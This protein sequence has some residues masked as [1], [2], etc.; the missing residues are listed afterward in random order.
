MTGI[1]T[2]RAVES[3]LPRLYDIWYHDEIAGEEDTPPSGPPLSGF[4]HSLERG[5]MRVAVDGN[6]AIMGFGATQ[7]WAATSGPL[8]YL[9]DLFVASDT[10]SHGAGQALLSALPMGQGA[11]CVMASRDPRATALYIRWGMRPQWPNYWIAADTP[12]VA[13]RLDLLPGAKLAVTLADLDD[14]ELA[15]WDL[16]SCGFERSHDLRWMVER[17][18]AQ[19]LWLTRGGERMGYAFVQRRC[20]ELL[21]RPKSWIIGPVGART[22][23]DAASCVGAVIRYAAERAPT[24]RLA[25]PGSHPILAPL[26]EAGFLIVYLETFLASE[27]AQPFDPAL[28]LPSGVYL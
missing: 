5:E 8:T 23:E 21:W 25:V 15:R 27:G 1:Q 9:S 24:I 12:N 16:E 14:P 10:Q 22:P 7:T 6:G 2:R 3:D 28:Y 11:R 4:A 20:N 18:D 19:P 26:V 13:H 17:R